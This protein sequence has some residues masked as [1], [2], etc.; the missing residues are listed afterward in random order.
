MAQVPVSGRFGLVYLVFNTLFGLLSQARQAE[1]FASVAR[2]LDPGGMFVIECFVPDLTRFDHDQRVQARSVAEDSAIIE[3]SVHDRVRQRV[4]TQMIT[5]DGQGTHLRPVVIRYT[6]PAELD[7]MAASAGLRLAAVR[8]W[9]KTRLDAG[10]LA[11]RP[12]GPVTVAKAYRLLH[13]ILA[14]AADDRLI[15]R[16]PC[17]ID[18][19]G[20]EE[21]D[22]RPVIPLPVVFDLASKVPARFRALV[23]LATFAQLRFGEL[24]GLR[25]DCL[26]PDA[27]EVRIIETT[28]QLDKGGLRTDTPKSAAGRRV[29]S[30]PP[31]IVPDLRI[32]LDRYAEVGPRGLVFVGPKDGQLRRQNFRPI[33]V[34]ACADAGIPGVHF[35]DLRHTGGTAAAITGATIK[36]LMARLGHSSPRAAMIYQHATRDRDK[37]IADALGQLADKARTKPSGPQLAQPSTHTTRKRSKSAGLPAERA[38]GIEPA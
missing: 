13:A 18:K 21:S 8:R 20:K 4:T 11:E 27:C 15:G 38:T 7:L 3:V 1:C 17:R 36:E 9:R 19:A 25:R 34:K 26:D 30:F 5:L 37:A 24:A 6:Y 35:H 29:V 16:N 14:T 33:W 32:H 23:L 10:P 28:A 22:E 12:F 2:A 31:E